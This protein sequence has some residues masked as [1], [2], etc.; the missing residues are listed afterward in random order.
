MVSEILFVLLIALSF[1]S[2][3]WAT[4]YLASGARLGVPSPRT[5]R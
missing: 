3:G 5:V 4:I 2:V 1:A